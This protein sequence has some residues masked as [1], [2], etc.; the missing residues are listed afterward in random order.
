M[1][2]SSSSSSSS[3]SCCSAPHS[4]SSL[5]SLSVS[6]PLLSSSFSP[7]SP[8]SLSSSL[9]L[10]LSL[11]LLTLLLSLS[12][13]LLSSLYLTSLKCAI[14]GGFPDETLGW[15]AGTFE[16]G[17]WLAGETCEV[18]AKFCSDTFFSLLFT[19]PLTIFC[20]FSVCL[21]VLATTFLLGF[22][23]SSLSIAERS[24]PFFTGGSRFVG[25]I[26]SVVFKIEEGTFNGGGGPDFTFCNFGG[27]DLAVGSKFAVWF[28]EVWFSSTIP[29]CTFL[30][31][32]F[33][34]PIF[35]C[36]WML[37][38]SL[39]AATFDGLWPFLL[40]C[41]VFCKTCVLFPD[42]K[43]LFSGKLLEVFVFS[44]SLLTLILASLTL[45]LWCKAK[46]P[47][48]NSLFLSLLSSLQ[49][50][51]FLFRCDGAISKSR[52]FPRSRQPFPS[53]LPWL[54]QCESVFFELL[55]VGLV[56]RTKLCTDCGL[57][58]GG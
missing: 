39:W 13:S 11:S 6:L 36:V 47:D 32:L 10:P 16:E 14:N 20:A 23:I 15:V 55:V 29:A 19:S 4:S 50:V 24:F 33:S 41:S 7:S 8:S 30:S 22:S 38:L 21:A 1:F 18:L 45:S 28:N 49:L 40:L 31:F 27:L 46:S 53:W 5:P 43:S 12:S 25:I 52:L 9:A 57:A 56:W 17:F 42:I 35:W 48:L 51:N 37:L 34:K 2:T 58:G 44:S 54:L 26:P 3:S